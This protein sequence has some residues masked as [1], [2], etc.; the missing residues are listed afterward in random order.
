MLLGLF[1]DIGQRL[2][3]K[4]WMHER[5]FLEI[6]LWIGWLGESQVIEVRLSGGLSFIRKL[7]FNMDKNIQTNNLL[8][9]KYPIA[10]VFPFLEII[11]SSTSYHRLLASHRIKPFLLSLIHKAIYN[12]VP[13]Y[14]S[15][16]IYLLPTNPLLQI[17]Y[18]KPHT[19][20][21]LLYPL[22]HL[23]IHMHIY[24]KYTE[25]LIYLS[26]QLYKMGRVLWFF[27][28]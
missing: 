5:S 27:L 20:V 8:T 22:T 7:W 28:K 24:S 12:L 17:L 6:I 25:H 18:S 15:S 1:S 2:C 11:W 9:L 19:S 10:F 16:Y 4:K 3:P 13:D 26:K 21:L 14:P 23:L